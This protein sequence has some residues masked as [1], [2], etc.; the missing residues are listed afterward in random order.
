MV[1][2]EYNRQ[3]AIEY[4]KKWALGR[5]DSYYNFD[6]LGGDC[7]NFVSQCIYAGALQMNYTPIFGWYYK[8]LNNRSPSWAG[9]EFLYNFLVNNKNLGPVGEISNVNNVSIGDIIQLGDQYENY[10]HTLIIT[11]VDNGIIKVASHTNDAFNRPLS[12]YSYS[13]ARYVHI[14]GINREN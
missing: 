6:E 11:S 14:L 5:N 4:A 7:T 8:N 2:V 12:T 3:L 9:V 13:T 1:F 10:Y